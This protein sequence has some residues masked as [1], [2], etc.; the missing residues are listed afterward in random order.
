MRQQDW[1][2]SVVWKWKTERVFADGSLQRDQEAGGDE[3]NACSLDE[4]E[5]VSVG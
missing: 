2:E 3:I 4:F 1:V 5:F